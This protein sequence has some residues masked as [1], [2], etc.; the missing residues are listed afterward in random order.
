MTNNTCYMTRETLQ[1]GPQQTLP[2][3]TRDVAV[4]WKR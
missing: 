3:M 4:W 2:E 1:S